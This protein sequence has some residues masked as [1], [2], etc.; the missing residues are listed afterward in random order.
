MAEKTK[1]VGPLKI[2]KEGVSKIG[3]S[4]LLT[5][6][7]AAVVAIGDTFGLIDFGSYENLALIA[8]PFIL[9]TLRKW[10]GSYES[11]K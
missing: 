6:G 3:K 10:L 7:S 1:L 8:V 9:N 11:K 2:D 5:V 4:F